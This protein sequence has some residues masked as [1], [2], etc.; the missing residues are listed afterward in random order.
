YAS[1]KA[2]V[3]AFS[4]SLRGEFA[5]HGV[6]VTVLYPGPLHTSLVSRGVSD[7][8]ERLRREERFLLARGLSLEHV[9]RRSLDRLVANPSRIVIGIDYFLFDLLS[10][11]S[12][13]LTARAMQF[14]SER[15]VV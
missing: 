6:G 7:S 1:S 11:L 13:R 2:A 5:E 12:A 9:A 10:R 4:E 8:P 15:A 14:G 3:R